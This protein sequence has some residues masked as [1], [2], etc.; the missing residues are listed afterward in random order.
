MNQ[1]V[2]VVVTIACTQLEDIE[3]AVLYMAVTLDNSNI[4]QVMG[5]DKVSHLFTQNNGTEMHEET[6]EAFLAYCGGR[7]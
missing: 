4:K 6:R 3:V 5:Y 2:Y 7:L 1:N